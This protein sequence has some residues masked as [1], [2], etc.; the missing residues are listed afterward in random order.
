MTLVKKYWWLLAILLF[1]LA[2]WTKNKALAI[3]AGVLSLIAA[4]LNPTPWVIGAAVW[5]LNALF[6]FLGAWSQ[7]LYSWLPG[8]NSPEP[9]LPTPILGGGTGNG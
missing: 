1:L 5:I 4:W 3:A 7:V 9:A 8:Q 2:V 6:G